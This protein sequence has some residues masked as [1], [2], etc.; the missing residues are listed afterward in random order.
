MAAH[1]YT[2]HVTRVIVTK[3]CCEL[4]GADM[5]GVTPKTCKSK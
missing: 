1:V 2:A 4:Q 5:P 3:L